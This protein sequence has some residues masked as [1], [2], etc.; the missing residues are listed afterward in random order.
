MKSDMSSVNGVTVQDPRLVLGWTE[1][2]KKYYAYA[3]DIDVADGELFATIEA[4]A[5]AGYYPKF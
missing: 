5:K 3:D 1:S 2:G 4:A